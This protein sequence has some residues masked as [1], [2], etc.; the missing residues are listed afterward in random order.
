MSSSRTIVVLFNRDL[1]VHDHPALAAAAREADELVSLFVLDEDEHLRMR[2]WLL[3][4]FHGGRMKRWGPLIQEITEREMAKWPVDIPFALR[5]SAE[6]ITLEVAREVMNRVPG[7]APEFEAHVRFHTFADSSVN[8]KVWLGAK[9]YVAG[10]KLKHEFIK[11]LHSRYNQEG[12]VIPSP[13]RTIDVPDKLLLKLR[14]H[15]REEVAV[16]NNSSDGWRPA[17]RL[18]DRGK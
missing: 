8:F 16:S 2:R 11:C 12:I 18:K 10:L 9:N 15:F 5:P 3:A 7:A 6:A 14:E 4:P 13:I 1:R 17:E